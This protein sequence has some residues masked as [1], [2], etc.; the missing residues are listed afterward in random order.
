MGL[1]LYKTE[2]H[3]LADLS[4]EDIDAIESH[5]Y[6]ADDGTYYLEQRELDDL[7]DH[8]TP[9]LH[10]DLQAELDANGDFNFLLS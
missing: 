8:V 6:H 5:V 3:H 10:K 7:K 1:S 9:E 4:P 2:L